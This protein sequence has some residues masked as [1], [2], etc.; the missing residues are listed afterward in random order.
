MEL[1]KSK[2][3]R[4][5]SKVFIDQKKKNKGGLRT[6]ERSIKRQLISENWTRKICKN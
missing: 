3:T 4:T 5:K 2:N 1:H 6:V